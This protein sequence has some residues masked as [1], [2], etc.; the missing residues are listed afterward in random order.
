MNR[1]AFLTAGATV[2]AVALLPACAVVEWGKDNH[3]LARFLVRQATFRALELSTVRA[4]RVVE[5]ISSVIS[6]V[7]REEMETIESIAQ[8]LRDEINWQDLSAADREVIALIVDEA[9]WRI[10]DR[11]NAG[12]LDGKVSVVVTT[13]LGWAHSAAAIMVN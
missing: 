3:T 7:D 9:E 2:P 13:V 12:E 1:R 11:I 8:R 4:V 6:Y 5:V 10:A